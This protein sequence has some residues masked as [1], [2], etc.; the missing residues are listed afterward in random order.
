MLMKRP[1]RFPSWPS[2]DAQ[3]WRR[4]R[5][6]CLA[7]AIAFAAVPLYSVVVDVQSA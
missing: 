1:G 3:R 7:L 2:T 4:F 6:G 5:W